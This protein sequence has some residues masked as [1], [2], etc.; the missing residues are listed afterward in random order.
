M[1]IIQEKLLELASSRNLGSLSLRELGEL[2]G[3]KHPQ[4]IKHHLVQLQNKGLLKVD[5]EKGTIELVDKGAFRNFVNIPILGSADCGPANIFADQKVEGYV[6]IS[7]KLI[8]TKPSLFA[9]RAVGSSMNRA[10]VN[11]KPIENGDYV[12]IDSELRS[13]VSGEYVL[14]VID[15]TCNIKKFVANNNQIS[16]ISESSQHFPP[17]VI[18]P[19]ETEYIVNGKV[20][21]VVKSSE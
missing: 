6:K 21:D 17:I 11:N 3:E 2:L 13:P 9:L 1:H 14:S 20:V 10:R 16:L 12:I 18:H 4:K 7:D 19:D 8:K 15:G 5:K